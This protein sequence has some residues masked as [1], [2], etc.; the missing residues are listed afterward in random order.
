[1]ALAMGQTPA[2]VESNIVTPPTRGTLTGSGANRTYTPSADLVGRDSFTF[3][4]SDGA[5]D[6]NIATVTL[7]VGGSNEAPVARDDSFSSSGV[8]PL[9]V[10]AS[11]MLSNHSDADDDVITLQVSGALDRD[12]A[13]EASKYFVTVRC[14][15]IYV[16]RSVRCCKDKHQCSR[17]VNH[18]CVSKFSPDFESF[19]T[20]GGAHKL[21]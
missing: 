5:L 6:S 4:A 7:E 19:E 9:T 12:A 17:C 16:T 2:Q 21:G 15:M 1:M 11:G 20:T 8:A 18:R 10:A 14:V 13:V 3:K